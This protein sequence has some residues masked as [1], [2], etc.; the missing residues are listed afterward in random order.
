MGG[1]SDLVVTVVLVKFRGKV[2]TD[3]TEKTIQ[4]ICSLGALQ[5][6]IRRTFKDLGNF[7][8]AFLKELTINNSPKFVTVTFH[9]FDLFKNEFFPY[10]SQ[11]K[12]HSGPELPGLGP[13]RH[14]SWDFLAIL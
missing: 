5:D 13:D 3:L 12:C 2:P 4:F 10:N 14:Q 7:R 9:F 6:N 1:Y 11:L 8:V